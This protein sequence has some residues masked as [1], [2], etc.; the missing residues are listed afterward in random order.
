MLLVIL[1]IKQWHCS[2]FIGVQSMS[3]GWFLQVM[4]FMKT[5][6]F[7]RMP[8]F[9]CKEGKAL[10]DVI[11]CMWMSYVEVRNPIAFLGK[12]HSPETGIN[13]SQKK[14]RQKTKQKPF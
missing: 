8:I 9:V 12:A 11:L 10:T 5:E 6:L 3:S 14:K 2:S 1:I 7:T 13:F 4:L